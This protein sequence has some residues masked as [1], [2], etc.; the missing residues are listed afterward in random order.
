[1]LDSSL[2]KQLQRNDNLELRII[3]KE[4]FMGVCRTTGPLEWW[5]N[6]LKL[7]ALHIYV[8]MYVCIAYKFKCQ[9]YYLNSLLGKV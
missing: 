3:S 2:G 8:C 6:F 1:V 9:Y 7:H 5:N 4:L